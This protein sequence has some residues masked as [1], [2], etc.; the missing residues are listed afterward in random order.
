[1]KAVDVR[2]AP[3]VVAEKVVGYKVA[4]EPVGAATEPFWLAGSSLRRDL[5]LPRLR[6]RW[7]PP[8]SA[9][10]AFEVRIWSGEVERGYEAAAPHNY[11]RSVMKALEGADIELRDCLGLPGPERWHRV[12]AQLADMTAV[13][14]RFEPLD[15]QLRRAHEQLARA[16]Q[17]P[18]VRIREAGHKRAIVLP[19][20][21][22]ATR[23]AAVAK[24]PTPMVFVGVLLL[25]YGLI[26]ALMAMADRY[27][28]RASAR[29]QVASAVQAL[30]AH[31][32]IQ[33]E[34]ARPSV[35]GEN[36]D[37][38]A[39]DF[40]SVRPTVRAAREDPR[41]APAGV[42]RASQRAGPTVRPPAAAS[43][44]RTQAR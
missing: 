15:T 16:A 6:E 28:L 12:A 30:A 25:V 43:A 18:R 32:K 27:Q 34:A 35:S 4:L 3:R 2:V 10:E 20:L 44:R 39:P 22:R 24:S 21:V 9:W 37:E 14:V 31:P 38:T 19:L 33:E 5:S 7:G 23:M 26:R 8:T 1:M 40:S 41:P 42:G 13:L 11:W 17:L 29:Q 36:A